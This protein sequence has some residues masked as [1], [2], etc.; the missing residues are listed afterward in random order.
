M[1]S[2]YW[3]PCGKNSTTHL[4][5]RWQLSFAVGKCIDTTHFNTSDWRRKEKFPLL[6]QF[7]VV[8]F[9]YIP[10]LLHGHFKKKTCFCTKIFH[11]AGTNTTPVQNTGFSISNKLQFKLSYQTPT[12]RYR[13]NRTWS[14]VKRCWGIQNLWKNPFLYKSFV[15]FILY[16]WKAQEFLDQKRN[17]MKPSISSFNVCH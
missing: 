4:I 8:Y 3:L 6:S 15:A 11:S 2:W 12:F 16:P 13:A 10:V 17:Q 14:I 9:Q 7:K 5:T 1:V